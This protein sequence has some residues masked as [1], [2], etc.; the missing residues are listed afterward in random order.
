MKWAMHT[1]IRA[2]RDLKKQHLPGLEYWCKQFSNKKHHLH[3]KTSLKNSLESH[4][5]KN[6]ADILHFAA[7]GKLAL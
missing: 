6:Y 5:I 2:N 4:N 7:R 3:M 1:R